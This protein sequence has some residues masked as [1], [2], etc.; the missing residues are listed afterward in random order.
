MV[1]TV[2]LRGRGGVPA[3]LMRGRDCACMTDEDVCPRCGEEFY[4]YVEIGGA[5]EGSPI[6]RLRLCVTEEGGFAHDV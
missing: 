3:F 2:D 6:G 4:E 5:Y 1:R